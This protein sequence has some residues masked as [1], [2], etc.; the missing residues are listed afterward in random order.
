MQPANFWIILW[1]WFITSVCISL[2]INVTGISE[3]CFFFLFMFKT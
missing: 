2:V 1:F 3:S